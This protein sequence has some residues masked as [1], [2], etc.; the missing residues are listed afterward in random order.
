MLSFMT[1]C[2]FHNLCAF[3]HHQLL[4]LAHMVPVG[5]KGH[6]ISGPIVKH[7]RTIIVKVLLCSI[8]DFFH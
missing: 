7:L 1:H 5:L 6:I 4:P 3:S 2:H 8:H